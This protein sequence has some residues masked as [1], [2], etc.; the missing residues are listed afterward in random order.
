[1]IPY[2]FPFLMILLGISALLFRDNLIKKV[3]G[4]GVL[5]NGTHLLLIT[6]GFRGELETAVPP[7]L[8]T[9]QVT[10]FFLANAVDP[11]PQALVLT[12][13]VINLSIF[14]LGLA[15]AMHAYRRFGT[16]RTGGWE[17]D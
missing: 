15:L 12:S 13:I 10:G 5:T 4:L 11:L 6:L 16:L 1:M 2:V 9:P 7:I 17:D 8:P 14:A 3:I